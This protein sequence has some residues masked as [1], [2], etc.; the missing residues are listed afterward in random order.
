[1]SIKNIPIF[2]YFDVYRPYNNETIEDL[3]YYII[4]VLDNDSR[5]AIL[6]NDKYSRVFG[7]VLK[8]IKINYT[9]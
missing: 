9:T 7:Y 8:Q 1:M 5:T 3:S 4:E 2:N 6:F